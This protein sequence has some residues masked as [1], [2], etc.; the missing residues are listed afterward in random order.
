MDSCDLLIVG[1]GPAGSSCAWALRSSGLRVVILDKAVFP[2]NKVCGGWVTPQ[3]FETLHIDPHAYAPG[4]TLQPICGFR[5]GSMGEGE[6]DVLYGHPVSYG[7]RRCEF[8]EYL[9][10]RSGAEVREGVLIRSIERNGDGWL[11]NGDIKARMLVGAGGHFC[12]VSRALGNSNAEVPVVAQEIELE[13][14]PGQAAACSIAPEAPE[15]YF[16]PDLQGYGWCFRKDNFLN[17][18]L[19]RL[20]QRALRGHVEGF[21]WFLH[22]TG[23]VAFSLPDRFPGHAY[24]LFGYSRRQLV[25]ESTLLIGD[26]AGLAYEQSGEGIRP[27]VES[28]LL[29][30]EVIR[31][32]EGQYSKER[33]ARY[34]DLLAE[35]FGRKPSALEA[36]ARRLPRVLRNFA[37]RQMLKSPS[38]CRQTVVD[39]WFLHAGEPALKINDDFPARQNGQSVTQI[40]NNPPSPAMAPVASQER[41]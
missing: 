28:G 21:L 14:T 9:L 10:R 27:A 12:P 37:A 17:I 30:A 6:V 7:I 40:L 31:E 16:C 25:A 2:R 20:D 8:D 11:V 23:K 33:L 26:A 19:G 34:Q 36:I 5:V 24:L 13:M 32:A 15:L 18:G 22:S 4:R 35:R 1:G 29:A 41:H 3:V 38:F 39:Q